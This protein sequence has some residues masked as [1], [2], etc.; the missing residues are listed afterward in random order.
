[1]ES[2]VG[3]IAAKTRLLR[4]DG[5]GHDLGFNGMQGLPALVLTDFQKFFG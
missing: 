4:I 1:M 3:L 5:A 2:A